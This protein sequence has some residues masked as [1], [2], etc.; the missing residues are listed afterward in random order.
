MAT[1]ETRESIRW[2]GPLGDWP[3]RHRSRRRQ[4]RRPMGYEDA[5]ETANTQVSVH[6]YGDKTLVFE[7]RGLTTDSLRVP[8]SA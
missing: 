7:V 6:D 1:W 8:R 3:D 5:G 2:I 4:L